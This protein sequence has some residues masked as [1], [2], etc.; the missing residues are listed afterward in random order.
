MTAAEDGHVSVVD[1]DQVFPVLTTEAAAR[2]GTSAP[3]TIAG[4]D[5]GPLVTSVLRTVLGWRPRTQDTQAFAAALRASFQ[6]QEVEGHI[7]SRYVPRGV[8][9]QADL[10]GVTGGQASLYARARGAMDQAS[11]LLDALKPLR[12]DFDPEDGEAFRMLV[13]HGFGRLVEELGNLGG[14]RQAIVDS[15]FDILLGPLGTT[16]YDP[17]ALQ[18]LAALT[19]DT[20]PGQLGALRDRFGLIDLN[21]NSPDEESLR[22]S[23]WTLVDLVLDLRRSWE[24]QK[25]LLGSGA[26][27]GF[28]GTDLVIVNRLLA[29]AAEQVDEV[30]A[31]LDS[32]LVGPAERQTITIGG[33]GS[34]LTLDGLLSWARRFLTE[35]GPL[36]L[37]EAGRDGILTA[38]AP[39]AKQLLETLTAGLGSVIGDPEGGSPAKGTTRLQVEDV[40][41]AIPLDPDRLPSGLFAARTRIAVAGLSRLLTE[42]FKTS[43]RISRFPGIVLFDVEF[44]RIERVTGGCFLRVEVRGANFRATYLPIFL[45]PGSADLGHAVLP[46]T[47]SATADDDSLT[48]IFADS[49]LPVYLDWGQGPR[50]ISD[51]PIGTTLVAP[52]QSVP[53]GV[54]DGETGQVIAAPPVRTWPAGGPVDGKRPDWSETDNDLLPITNPFLVP[55]ASPVDQDDE[56][57]QSRIEWLTAHPDEMRRLLDDVSVAAARVASTRGSTE[58]PGH[59]TTEGVATG[60]AGT[61]AAPT[62]VVGLGVGGVPAPAASATAVLDRPMTESVSSAEE[63]PADESPAEESPADGTAAGQ[64]DGR[65]ARRRANPRAA[66]RTSASRATARTAQARSEAARKGAA[67]RARNR[68]AAE[69]QN[70]TPAD[71]GGAAERPDQPGTGGG[72]E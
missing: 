71:D 55:E 56:R 14:P 68:A 34:G 26:G 48:A 52:A 57:R 28:L 43:S 69:A 66:S 2:T 38:F 40:L 64:G 63:S 6:L 10:G 47:G 53:I 41:H 1:V 21:V 31:V 20:V 60:S 29:A 25:Q 27:N 58:N 8:A 42:V 11:K 70:Q 15:A 49:D 62:S 16:A 65:G 17:K 35:D 5:Q 61:G 19:P 59:G 33:P 44:A 36:Y 12:N 45:Q 46:R 72:D 39:E 4:Q 67:T 30:E 32:A 7:E 51:L 3:P 23:F 50:R 22:T 9:V 24:S 13:R 54:L 18:R 37:R